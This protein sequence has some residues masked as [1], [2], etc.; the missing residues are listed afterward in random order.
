MRALGG[1][2][3]I[4]DRCVEMQRNKHGETLAEKPH[5]EDGAKR[6]RGPP[7]SVCP[8][9]KALA[10]Q[11]MRDGILGAVQDIE[12][13]V[14]LGQE[15]R[16]CPYYATRLA[17]PPAQVRSSLGGHARSCDFRRFEIVLVC[18]LVSAVG[19][20]A[21]SDVASRCNPK[22]SRGAAEGTG[23][24]G[25]RAEYYHPCGATVHWRTRS[26][27]A[28]VNEMNPE[29]SGVCLQVAIIDEAHNLSETLSCIHSA[30]LTGAQVHTQQNTPACFKPCFAKVQMFPQLCRTH[31]QLTQYA[32][33]FR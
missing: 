16:S 23:G 17:I 13:L 27:A 11:R 29:A 28:R 3:R 4:N 12:Q 7:K 5:H 15:T 6:K 22:S 19:G 33:R 2:Q 31:S 8:Y 20:V 18:L 24:S 14:K 10:Q 25:H 21:L 30:D 9:N 32:D 1:I 26:H